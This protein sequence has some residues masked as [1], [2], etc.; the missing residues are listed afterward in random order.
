M[1]SKVIFFS[2]LAITCV[3]IWGIFNLIFT[4]SSE[5]MVWCIVSG[6][7]MSAALLSNLLVVSSTETN[8]VRNAS[9]TWVLNASGIA[10][11]AWTLFFVFLLGSYE[12]GERSMTVLYVGYLVI[13]IVSV[14]LIFMG[15]WGGSISEKYSQDVQAS[16]QGRD[17][18][19]MQLKQA[20][21]KL[22]EIESDTRTTNH[23]ALAKSFDLLKNIPANR[24]SDPT[25]SS[26]VSEKISSVIA[27]VEQNDAESIYTSIYQLSQTLKSIRL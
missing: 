10:F 12:D 9:L 27:S 17:V 18:F 14:F 23:K 11:F 22:E 6:I 15:G 4:E 26:Q 5:M 24:I 1:R 25:V 13:L 20:I 2:T 3:A 21:V 8:T 7:A 16:I 19:I